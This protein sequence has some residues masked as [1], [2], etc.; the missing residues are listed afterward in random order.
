MPTQLFDHE[1]LDIYR[2]ELAFIQWL[3]PLMSECKVAEAPS[4]EILDQIDRASLSALLNT[5]EGNDKRQG[6][7]RARFFDDARGSLFECAACLDA[8]VA[9]GLVAVGRIH[10][11]KAMLLRVVSLLTRMVDGFEGNGGRVREEE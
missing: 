9:K 1:K 3:S 8:M 7:Q 11:G 5:A 4:R 10:E 6:K 2:L